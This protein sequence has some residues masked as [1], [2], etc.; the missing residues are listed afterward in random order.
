M[1]KPIL[2]EIQSLAL[3]SGN[4]FST[5]YLAQIIAATKAQAI[6]VAVPD[7][8][9]AI[10]RK[11]ADP[12]NS[13]L[14]FGF[15]PVTYTSVGNTPELFVNGKLPADIGGATDPGIPAQYSVKYWT[16]AWRQVI[17]NAID[18]CVSHGYDGIFLDSLSCDYYWLPGNN[19]GNAPVAN[20]TQLLAETLTA[21]RAYVNSKNLDHPF[22]LI[23]NSPTSISY[24]FPTSLKSLDAI[25][26]EN[27]YASLDGTTGDGTTFTKPISEAGTD[28]FFTHTLPQWMISGV[29]I[30]GNDYYIWNSPNITVQSFLKYNDKGIVFSETY[31]LNYGTAFLDGPYFF[32]ANNFQPNVIGA[33]SAQ[34]Y[35]AGGITASALLIGGDKND[36][37]AGGDGENLI[38]GQGGDDVIYAHPRKFLDRN[39]LDID[40]K[41]VVLNGPAPSLAVYV[42][43]NLI[44]T[45]VLIDATWENQRIQHI[46]VDLG[47]VNEIKSI[48]LQG[49]NIFWTDDSHFNLVQPSGISLNGEFFPFAKGVVSGAAIIHDDGGAG[50]ASI[51]VG[52]SITFNA[53]DL[54]LKM[55]K[56]VTDDSIDGGAGFDTVIYDRDLKSYVVNY[57]VVENRI[58][59]K[60]PDGNDTL[61]NVE[62]IQ[63][64][65]YSINTTM[66]AE[67]A[68]LPSA[69]VNSLVE[70]YVAYFAR[71]PDA[72]GL[73]YWINKAAGGES[74]TDISKEFYNA[75]VQ[76][77]SL[78]GYSANMANNDFTKIVYS[79][80]LGRTGATAPNAD[81]LGYWDNQIKTGA[82]TKEGLIQRMLHDAHSFAGDPKWGW[83]PK[84]LDNKIEVGY[85][86]AVTFGLDYNSPTD[87]ITQGMAIA[88]AVTPTDTS[89]AVGLI[90]VADHVFL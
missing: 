32:T 17:F 38:Q 16:A 88:K 14:I 76:F 27:L 51:G 79:N 53:S 22:Y 39:I 47:N 72:S 86:A 59:V 71:T 55:F 11:I 6:I 85:K 15:M 44:G 21:I 8:E 57:S 67:A 31:T 50:T 3:H 25:F 65:D 30:F 43:G 36:L 19:L 2:K 37:I 78:T 62:K 33:L 69:T 9:P 35:L 58:S 83:V 56:S 61:K 7:S 28:W 89:I 74:L 13:K 90:G 75:G 12:T 66:K 81:E 23:G 20:A 41:S 54:Q 5:S 52:G 4:F 29:Q 1:V 77:S 40:V 84:L 64:A 10:D 26:N 34:N 80:V 70:L 46:R 18:N 45:S 63:F 73:S 24:D 82:T 42:N 68:K 60:S 87:A 48:S 49:K